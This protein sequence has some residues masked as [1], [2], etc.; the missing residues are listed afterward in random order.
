MHIHLFMHHKMNSCNSVKKISRRDLREDGPFVNC[1]DTGL[2]SFSVQRQAY[3]G[4]TFIGNHVH[5]CLKV[6][7]YNNNKPK[8]FILLQAKNID[9]LCDAVVRDLNAHP[10]LDSASNVQAKFKQVLE[11]FAKCH[12]IYNSTGLLEPPAI[13]QLRKHC[14]YW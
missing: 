5:R 11:L 14:D 6:H 10:L 8:C 1:S 4:G 2:S 9:T 13:E 7:M 3:Y 12:N